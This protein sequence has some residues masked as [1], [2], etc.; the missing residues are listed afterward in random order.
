MK[1]PDNSEANPLRRAHITLWILI[2]GMIAAAGGLALA[3]DAS[4]SPL[5]G[6]GFAL[7]ST[8]FVVALIL[9]GRVTVALERSRRRA[10]PTTSD[11][12]PLPLIA[13]L[14]RQR[15]LSHVQPERIRRRSRRRGSRS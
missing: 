3:A 11:Q 9:A 2:G 8:I 5:V 10:R 12:D 6:I 1:A 4:P 13:Q 7:S 15:R 14:F